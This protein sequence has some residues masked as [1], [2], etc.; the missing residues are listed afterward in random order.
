[1]LDPRAAVLT[2]RVGTFLEGLVATDEVGAQ[3]ARF[4][5]DGS[6][7]TSHGLF[8]LLDPAPLGRTAPVVWLGGDIGN[9]ADLQ[10]SGLQRPDRGLPARARA[11]DEYVDLAHP[12]LLRLA[13]GV[14]GGQLSGERC[15]LPRTLEA[16]VAR[17]R[18]GDDVALRVGDRHDRVVESA[19]DVRGAV[20]DVLLFP[21]AGLLSL[22]GRR[23]TT[24]LLRWHRLPGLLLACDGALRSL[25]CS[26][27][28]LCP[29]AAHRHAAAV[30]QTLVAADL[31]LAADVGLHLA[32]QITF[33]LQVGFDVVTQMG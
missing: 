26:R 15:G 20:R 21:P 13:G 32:A 18:P 12:V 22:L 17:G 28:G 29:L 33:H 2:G 24:R 30:P 14:F 3:P 9:R 8:L 16:D 1:F 19:L 27:I 23:S 4:A 10:A 6:G 31:D 5:S 25:A 7:V 11:L